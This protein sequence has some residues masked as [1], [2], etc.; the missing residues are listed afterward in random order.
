MIPRVASQVIQEW[1]KSGKGIVVK[2]ARPP[3]AK[4]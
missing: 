2:G 4:D 3:Q 1:M